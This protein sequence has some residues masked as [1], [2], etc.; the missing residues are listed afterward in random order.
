MLAVVMAIAVGSVE[1]T[2]QNVDTEVD[3]IGVGIV[4]L[5]M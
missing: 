2:V 4:P 3:I 5:L 1:D